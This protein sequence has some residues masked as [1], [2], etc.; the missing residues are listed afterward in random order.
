MSDFG[1]CKGLKKFDFYGNKLGV[2]G[3]NSKGIS[4]LCLTMRLNSFNFELAILH[5]LKK[6]RSASQK[7]TF[8]LSLQF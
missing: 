4:A 7:I 3:F 8:S 2:P 1:W 6:F 5:S